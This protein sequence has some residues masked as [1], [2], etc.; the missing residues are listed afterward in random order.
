MDLLGEDIEAEGLKLSSEVACLH[1]PPADYLR[2]H[3][4]GIKPMPHEIAA[5]STTVHGHMDGLEGEL[6][7]GHGAR[8]EVRT[9]SR[10]TCMED[11]CTSRFFIVP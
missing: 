11:Y 7:P 2:S 4:W 8:V 5:R 9:S 3:N 10:H 6:R 1:W